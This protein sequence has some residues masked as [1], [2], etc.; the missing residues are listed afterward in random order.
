M[1][2]NWKKIEGICIIALCI[3]T[4][5]MEFVKIPF[6]EDAFRNRMLSGILQQA[7]GGV[8]MILLILR[9]GLQLFGKPENLLFLVPCFVIAIDNFPFYS[10]FQGNM[11]LVRTEFIDV[12]LFATHC[13]LV[14][15]FE[16][17]I[18]RGILFYAI[19]SR[20][21]KDKNG[22]I[23][24]YVVSSVVFGLA[25]LMNIF[26]GNVGAVLLQVGYSTLTGGLFAF[27]LIKTKNIFCAGAVHAVYN[28]CGLIFSERGLG[29]GV[30]FDLGTG[31]IMAVVS[32]AIGAFVLI[33][34]FRY[35][36]KDREE[37]YKRLNLDK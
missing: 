22:F 33:N 25:H 3:A 9:S 10:Y 37:L 20:F 14:G 29:L 19:A 18:F 30:V 5:V 31:I 1:R 7:F 28:F 34:V 13:L 6:T 17:S 23:K 8:A 2:K 16:E 27:A 15:I 32:I 24:T 35:S 26:G 11:Q 36:D 4:C 12:A 21:S